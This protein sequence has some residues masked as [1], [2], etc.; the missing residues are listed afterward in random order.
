MVI[1]TGVF[2]TVTEKRQT[3]LKTIAPGGAA[4]GKTLRRVKSTLDLAKTTYK[5]NEILLSQQRRDFRHGVR[6]VAGQISGELSV[7]GYQDFCESICRQVVQAQITTGA[8]VTVTSAVT[9]T[10][11]GTF[12]RSAGSYITDGF[13]V[14][15]VVN[16]SG[17]AT[18]GVPN[19]AHNMMIV[20]LTALVMTVQT[21]DGVAIGAKAAGDSVTCVTVGK[22]TWLPATGQVRHYYTIEHF[23]SDISQSE[24]FQDVVISEMAVKLPPTGMATVD[25]TCMGLDMPVTN[26][27]A[28]FTSPT[29]APTGGIEASVN[30]LLVVNGVAVAIITAMDFSV[31]GNYS[32]PGGV[33]GANV[34]PDVFP[35]SVDVTGNITVLFQDATFRD[36]FNLE[37]EFSIFVALTANNTANAPFTAFQFPRVKAGG[38]SKDDQEKGLSLTMPFTALEQ[39]AAGGATFNALDTTFSMQDSAFA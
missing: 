10:P 39:V 31:K 7:G 19:N 8:I 17:F 16:W 37:T 6:S 32:V 15:D 23:F 4:T 28:Y 27:V 12:T 25:F 29:A 33:V 18:T 20:A 30:G 36:Y 5:S 14:G 3:A 26:T 11:Q 1:A 38:A 2:K 21:L 35:G 24:V 13:K 22:K 34:D 9:T